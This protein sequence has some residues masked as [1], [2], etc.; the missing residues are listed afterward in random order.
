MVDVRS[1]AAGILPSGT[2]TIA[3]D[4]HEIT[5]VFGVRAV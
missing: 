5:N 3:C 4:N 2:T 1:F